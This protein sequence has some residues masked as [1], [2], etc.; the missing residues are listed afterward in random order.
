MFHWHHGPKANTGG[1]L[2]TVSSEKGMS[3]YVCGISDG[4]VSGPPVPFGFC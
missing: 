1:I 2:P 3:S 4:V